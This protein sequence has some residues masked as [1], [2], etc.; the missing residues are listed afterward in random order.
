MKQ[1]TKY[2]SFSNSVVIKVAIV[3]HVTW[4]SSLGLLYQIISNRKCIIKTIVNI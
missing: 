4:D 1:N 2:E 3:V